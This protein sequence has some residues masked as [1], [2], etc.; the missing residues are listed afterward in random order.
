MSFDSVLDQLFAKRGR[1]S[2]LNRDYFVKKWTK[3]SEN[4]QDTIK[5]QLFDN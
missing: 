4:R 3:E 5:I 1:F 2:G